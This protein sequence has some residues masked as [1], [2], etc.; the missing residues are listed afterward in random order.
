MKILIVINPV[1]P[2]SQMSVEMLNIKE[3]IEWPTFN[4]KYLQETETNI[5]VQINGKKRGLLKT[6]KNIS[7]QNVLKKIQEDDKLRNFIADKKIKK[8]IYVK[9]KIINLII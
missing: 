6:M 9:N 7:E 2:H 8:Q 5:V 3:N 1:I 4:E